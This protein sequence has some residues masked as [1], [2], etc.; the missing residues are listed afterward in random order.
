MFRGVAVGMEPFQRVRLRHSAVSDVCEVYA[1]SS[2]ECDES[3]ELNVHVNAHMR[4]FDIPPHIRT[5]D[6]ADT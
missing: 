2:V 3:R 6:R 4:S 5:A 1:F